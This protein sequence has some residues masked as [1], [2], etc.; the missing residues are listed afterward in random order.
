MVTAAATTY[1]FKLFPSGW[2]LN[3]RNV[4]FQQKGRRCNDS[5]LLSQP[6]TARWLS[7]WAL[8]EWPGSG[9]SRLC[10]QKST[11]FLQVWGTWKEKISWTVL[12]PPGEN[13]WEGKL[14]CRLN[15]LAEQHKLQPL[16]SAGC[17]N[18]FVSQGEMSYLSLLLFLK[19]DFSEHPIISLRILVWGFFCADFCFPGFVYMKH[20]NGFHTLC[21]RFCFSLDPGCGLSCSIQ[22]AGALSAHPNGAGV[23]NSFIQG[24][25]SLH[26]RKPSQPPLCWHKHCWGQVLLSRS[27]SKSMKR[28]HF[29]KDNGFVLKHVHWLYAS[30]C[31][32]W[33]CLLHTPPCVAVQPNLGLSSSLSCLA[34]QWALILL[35]SGHWTREST[36]M[37]QRWPVLWCGCTSSWGHSSGWVSL[38]FQLWKVCS[39]SFIWH[40]MSWAQGCLWLEFIC[41]DKSDWF[42]SLICEPICLFTFHS[43]LARQLEAGKLCLWE[44]KVLPGVQQE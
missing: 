44:G 1:I 8:R 11:L 25:N 26:T 41:R 30:S 37:L 18:A 16:G 20:G 35:K 14:R 24:E 3:C 31:S 5:S 17:P 22:P 12:L 23:W 40:H 7:L 10:P 38:P 32:Q 2:F 28:N 29:L 13:N 19:E 6:F 33:H 27:H 43:C 9:D 36:L 21:S 39:T 4:N 34:T 15:A 42:W